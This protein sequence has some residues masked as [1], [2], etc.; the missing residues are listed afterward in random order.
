MAMQN[1]KCVVV[2]D[3]AVGKTRFVNNFLLILLREKYLR[4]L[5]LYF[6]CS[7]SQ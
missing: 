1:V 7:N 3:G 5:F 4:L 6:F 2:G